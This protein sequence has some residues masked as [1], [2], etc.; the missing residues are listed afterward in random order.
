M[1]KTPVVAYHQGGIAYLAL[2]VAHVMGAC[3]CVHANGQ[4]VPLVGARLAGW[5]RSKE[6]LPEGPVISRL[7]INASTVCVR[8]TASHVFSHRRNHKNVMTGAGGG[9]GGGVV[10]DP[11]DQHCADGLLAGRDWCPVFLSPPPLS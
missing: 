8:A 5:I 11:M 2:R 3:A 9:D 1:C 7:S 10:W 6:H 4:Q